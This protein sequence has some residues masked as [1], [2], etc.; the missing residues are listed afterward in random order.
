MAY[1]VLYSTKVHRVSIKYNF[2]N[3]YELLRPKFILLFYVCH[4][5]MIGYTYSINSLVIHVLLPVYFVSIA[6]NNFLTKPRG[7]Y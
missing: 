2:P 1:K 5:L 6:G 7:L 4:M 3:L